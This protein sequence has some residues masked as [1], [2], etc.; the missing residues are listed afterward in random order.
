MAMDKIFDNH[1]HSLSP[2]SS[3]L[4]TLEDNFL[5]CDNGNMLFHWSD[6]SEICQIVRE[7]LIHDPVLLSDFKTRES[8]I[9][10]LQLIPMWIR[11]KNK[12]HQTT[13]YSL[14]EKYIL[15][16][17]DL[18]SGV[19]AFSDLEISF[20]S[21]T[22]PFKSMSVNA[23][24][25]EATFSN[26]I[27]VYLVSGKLKERNYRVRLKSKILIE[28]GSNYSKVELCSLEQLS[29]EGMLLSTDAE[30]YHQ[31]LSQGDNFRILL[32]TTVLSNVMNKSL[33]ELK[34][35]LSQYAFNLMYSSSKEESLSFK[36]SD[37]IVQ[38]S[39]NF[40]QNKKVFFFIPYDK[41]QGKNSDSV[42]CIKD[43][44]QFTKEIALAYYGRRE[45][46]KSA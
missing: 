30:M 45:L 39:F 22:G 17:M 31:K 10:R 34:S 11:T 9:N 43:F 12:V 18:L 16:R 2:N 27:F 24:F 14:Y 26:F 38:S 28:H 33:G 44:V 19:D 46:K 6:C 5:F 42:D 1:I 4:K 21:G 23:C 7:Q 35:Y 36:T 20:I 25:N 41:L 32:N 8:S 40:S 37:V 3:P 29:L 15:D 13:M